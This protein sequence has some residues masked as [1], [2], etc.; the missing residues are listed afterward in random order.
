MSLHDLEIFEAIAGD[1][2]TDLGLERGFD[3][4]SPGVAEAVGRYEELWAGRSQLPPP[5]PVTG[6][7]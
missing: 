2:L 6:T 7:G 1:M 4:I 5:L 3:T